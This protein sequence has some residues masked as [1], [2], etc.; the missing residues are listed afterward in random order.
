MAVSIKSI[1]IIE[2]IDYKIKGNKI[3][4]II[5]MSIVQIKNNNYLK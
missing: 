5:V 4:I 2:W 1:R 3:V